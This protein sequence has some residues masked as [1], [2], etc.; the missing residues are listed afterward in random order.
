MGTTE[1]TTN[2]E[3]L[4]DTRR[5][6][7]PLSSASP[8]PSP[9]RPCVLVCV[10]GRALASFSSFLPP[11]EPASLEIRGSFTSR[12]LRRVV[13][14]RFYPLL[15]LIYQ[16]PPLFFI[17]IPCS[18]VSFLTRVLTFSRTTWRIVP[19][20]TTLS[21]THSLTGRSWPGSPFLLARRSADW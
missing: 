2:F 20:R 9:P 10:F 14:S 1:N 3:P 15:L 17:P 4:G 6:Q 7:Y 16:Q 21:L 18:P 8:A 12:S 11:R 19:G 5:Q 13:S